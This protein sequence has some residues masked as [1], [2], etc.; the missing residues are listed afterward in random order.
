MYAKMSEI[1]PV[2]GTELPA[3]PQNFMEDGANIDNEMG[4]I[5]IFRT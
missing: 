2:R 4:N 5:V 3:S 1:R